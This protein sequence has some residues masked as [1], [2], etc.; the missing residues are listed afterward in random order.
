MHYASFLSIQ[1]EFSKRKCV[2]CFT[3]LLICL[4][5]NYFDLYS[6]SG[7]FAIRPN[8]RNCVYSFLSH[9]WIPLIISR[10][11]GPSRGRYPTS[12]GSNGQ[13]LL[14]SKVHEHAPQKK[15]G[16]QAFLVVW[17]HIF[18]CL[19]FFSFMVLTEI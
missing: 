2:L 5:I 18:Q 8:V 3:L 6:M 14:M 4:I 7:K 1:F 9:H 17:S 19:R 10:W 12:K 16:V 15:K 11:N 13:S